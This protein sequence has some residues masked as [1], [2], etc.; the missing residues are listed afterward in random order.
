MDAEFS[1]REEAVEGSL[2]V[3][4]PVE[5]GTT[6]VGEGFVGFDAEGEVEFDVFAGDG[7]D[8]REEAVT[9]RLCKC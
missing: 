2:G 4:I 1:C 5:T 9:V 3:A 6:A 7:F 8:C